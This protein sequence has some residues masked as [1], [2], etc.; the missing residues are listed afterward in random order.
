MTEKTALILLVEDDQPTR[1]FLKSSLVGHGWQIAE[2]ES[3]QTCLVSVKTLNPDLVVLDLGLPDL[4]GIMVVRALRQFS[5]LPI[6]I[7]SARTQEQDR[8]AALNAGADDYLTKPFSTGELDARIRALLR[9]ALKSLSDGQVFLMGDLRV[10]LT[11]RKV[12]KSG[13]E[14]HL[15]PIEYRL[16]SMLIRH[17]G[18]VVTHRQLLKSIWGPDHVQDIQYLRIYM[19]QLRHKLEIDPARPRH[20]ITEAG[21]G[22]RLIG[23][24]ISQTASGHK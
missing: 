19:G 20:L 14:V 1:R 23:Q 9:R 24:E 21:V 6:L 3:G 11:L 12:L 4:D 22:Y 7:L 10:D 13:V 17:A 16:L 5:K 8:I 18:L 15:T 2:A